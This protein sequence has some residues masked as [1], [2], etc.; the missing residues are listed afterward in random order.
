MPALAEIAQKIRHTAVDILA[1]REHSQKELLDKL[2]RRF[3]ESAI[4]REQLAWLQAQDLQSDARFTEQFIRNKSSRGFGR[5]RIRME[6]QQ[7]GIA[8]DMAE[9]ALAECGVDWRAILLDVV[10]RKYG[11]TPATDYKELAKRARYLQ[12]RGFDSEAIRDVVRLVSS[13]QA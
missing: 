9:A 8:D 10:D 13:E 7:R 11:D 2:D 5:R 1:R 4:V 6:L 12:G 3:P